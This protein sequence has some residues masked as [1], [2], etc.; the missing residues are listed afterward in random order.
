MRIDPRRIGGEEGGGTRQRPARARGVASVHDRKPASPPAGPTALCS[1]FHIFDD[2]A[3]LK[4]IIGRARNRT[5]TNI[6][7]D[8][9]R[10]GGGRRTEGPASPP[11][12]AVRRALS[13]F[14]GEKQN[15]FY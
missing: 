4:T 9:D 11:L 13:F 10:R 12:L 1:P 3:S 8:I 5:D 6:A 7:D 14:S 15:T 2:G